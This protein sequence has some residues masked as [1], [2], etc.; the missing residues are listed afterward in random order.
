MSLRLNNPDKNLGNTLNFP[1]ESTPGV[2][3]WLIWKFLCD[4]LSGVITVFPA[5][6]I[7]NT[8]EQCAKSVPRWHIQNVLTISSTMYHFW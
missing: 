5:S 3:E 1:K 4:V 8:P 7:Q 2:P 6:K